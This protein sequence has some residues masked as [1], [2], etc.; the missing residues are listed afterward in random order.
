MTVARAGGAGAPS[1]NT[2]S[3]SAVKRTS[4]VRVSR[5]ATNQSP[6][7]ERWF[8]HSRCTPATFLRK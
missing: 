5:S 3:G 8:H 7:P 6:Q 4:F 1:P 2:S